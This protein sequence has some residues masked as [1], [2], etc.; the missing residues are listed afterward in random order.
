MATAASSKMA[1]SP[2]MPRSI[3]LPSSLC[4]TPARRELVAKRRRRAAR[5]RRHSQG[6]IESRRHHRRLPVRIHRSWPLR[7]HRKWRSRQ[8]C[9]ARY[10]CRAVSVPRPRGESSLQKDGVVQR[11]IAGIRKAKLNLVVITD[12][13]LCEYTDH[14]HC[15]VIENGEVANDATLDILAEQSLSHARAER[16]RCKKT[17]SCSAPSQA[18]ARQN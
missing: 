18:F 7:R 6:K 1:K 17:A 11:A 14:G 15:G 3:F 2:T 4:P 5:H 12:V 8:R 10:S 16:A 9:H 13:C